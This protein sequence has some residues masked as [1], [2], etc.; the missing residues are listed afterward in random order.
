VAVPH[1][2][3]D[4]CAEMNQASTNTGSAP[5]VVGAMN[6]HVNVLPPLSW[7]TTSLLE[8]GWVFFLFRHFSCLFLVLPSLGVF[9]LAS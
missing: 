8:L 5:L 9:S 6:G 2:L 7:L 1:L 3:L 4:R